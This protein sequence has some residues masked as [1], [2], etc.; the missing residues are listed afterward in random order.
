M[1]QELVRTGLRSVLER[2]DGTQKHPFV[3]VSSLG[4]VERVRVGRSG[5]YEKTGDDGTV[6]GLGPS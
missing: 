5:I 4:G 3:L 1:I 6:L 2:R